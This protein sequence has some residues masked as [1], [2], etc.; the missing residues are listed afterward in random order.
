[1]D[2]EVDRVFDVVSRCLPDAGVECLMIGGHAVNHYGYTRATQ[3][4][5]FMIAADDELLVRRV[6][7]DAGYIN[8]SVHENVVFYNRPGSPLRVDFLKVERPTLQGLLSGAL[9]IQYFGGHSV[10]VPQLKD[11]IAMKIFA[12]KSARAKRL[13]KD[14]PDIAHLAVLHG[15]DLQKDLRP[16]CERFGT[17]ALF[18][19]LRARIQELRNA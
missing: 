18:E 6:M 7:T 2:F 8:V 13:D 14:L 3:D 10:K 11:L 5:D 1:M 12:L 19:L 4:V 17:P 15:L 16:L 9:S